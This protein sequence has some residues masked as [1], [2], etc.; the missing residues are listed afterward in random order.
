MRPLLIT[1]LTLAV[2]STAT[3]SQ[4]RNTYEIYA[5]EYAK[6]PSPAPISQIAVGSTSRDSVNLWFYFWYLKGNNGSNILVDVGFIKDTLYQRMKDYERPDLALRPLHVDPDSIT[7]VIITHAHGDHIDGIDL[8]KKAN[9]WM[10]RNEFTYFVVD[11]WQ[12]GGNH[13]GLD[14]RDVEK[15]VRVNLEGRLHLVDGDSIEILPGIRAFIGSKHTFESQHLLVNTSKEPV[16]L[17]SDDSW[18]YVNIDSL[19]SIPLTFDQPGYIRQLKRMR[20]LVPDINLIIP[21]HDAAV[22]SRF[23]KVADRIVRIR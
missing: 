4:T 8:F 12:K 3:V 17:A 14:K 20:S 22:M 16:L 5:I 21:G 9:V 7:D 19:Y 6:A 10:Q 1:L 18:F 15:I 2:S 11:A 13:L 23:P